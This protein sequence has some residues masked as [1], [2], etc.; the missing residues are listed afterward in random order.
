MITVILMLKEQP[1]VASA[2]VQVLFGSTDRSLPV[3]ALHLYSCA[4]FRDRLPVEMPRIDYRPNELMLV[5]IG[6]L[7]WHVPARGP[8]LFVNMSPCHAVS[9]PV[10]HKTRGQGLRN[11]LTEPQSMH[12]SAD[13]FVLRALRLCASCFN[14]L[15]VTHAAPSARRRVV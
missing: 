6:S 8:A 9:T 15:S 1:H 7:D 10:A 4:C 2:P 13:L 12:N 14:R 11:W 3:R 5:V